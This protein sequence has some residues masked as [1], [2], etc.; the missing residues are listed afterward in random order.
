MRQGICLAFLVLTCLSLCIGQ[1]K[2]EK[3][4]ERCLHR[5]WMQNHVPTGPYKFLEDDSYKGAP[6]FK[7]QVNEDGTVSG[8]KLICSSGVRDIDR[9]VIIAVAHW[10]YEPGPGCGIV[11]TNMSLT[12]DW[13]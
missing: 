1:T 3:P 12:I 13:Q 2:T 4:S 10:K 11:E 9:K 6:I 8:V 5:K 7:F